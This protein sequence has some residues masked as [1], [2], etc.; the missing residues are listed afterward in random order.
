MSSQPRSNL[1]P[2]TLVPERTNRTLAAAAHTHKSIGHSC[3]LCSALRF[4]TN[5]PVWFRLGIPVVGGYHLDAQQPFSSVLT[6][7]SLAHIFDLVWPVRDQGT[8]PSSVDKRTGPTCSVLDTSTTFTKEQ[9]FLFF[10]GRPR[11]SSKS[12]RQNNF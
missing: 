11:L 4:H 10:T 5:C 1:R 8:L 2:D 12:T 6:R 7:P 9:G 3:C